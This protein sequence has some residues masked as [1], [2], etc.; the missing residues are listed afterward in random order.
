M[1][2]LNGAHSALKNLRCDMDNE[3][4]LKEIIEYLESRENNTY[5]EYI[6]HLRQDACLGWEI[7]VERGLFHY[8]ELKAHTT[9]AELLGEHRAFSAMAK[10]LREMVKPLKEADPQDEIRK[11]IEELQYGRT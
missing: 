7:K 10:R 2:G 9:A 4:L 11:I 5:Y 6:N 1:D 3:N 8:P